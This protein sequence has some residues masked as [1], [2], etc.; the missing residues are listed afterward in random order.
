[1]V[2]RTP[3]NERGGTLVGGEDVNKDT[4]RRTRWAPLVVTLLQNPGIEGLEKPSKQAEPVHNIHERSR[5][6]V[7]QAVLISA[8]HACTLR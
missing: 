4:N 6:S 5:S 2:S 7:I 1:M 8:A 3:E